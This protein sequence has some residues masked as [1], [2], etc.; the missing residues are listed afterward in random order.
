ML[1]FSVLVFYVFATI[2]LVSSCGV[3][4]SRNPVYSAL[5]LVVVFVA[6]AGIWL[7]LHAEFLALVLV[8]VYVG[9]VM[10]LFLFVLMM[11]DINLDRLREGFWH[12]LPLALLLAIG[13]AWALGTVLT[14]E[15]FV[16]SARF[17]GGVE[18][19]NTRA[20]GAVLYTD[21][22]YP[23]E[24]AAVILLVA[25]IA[26]VAL[27]LRRRK[28]TKHTDVAQQVCADRESRVRLISM[29]GGG[30]APT[31]RLTTSKEELS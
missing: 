7:L 6:S 20:L 15:N 12:Y 22:A 16:S 24:L 28:N 18:S 26:A 13:V 31:S 14:N 9:A 8:L 30:D 21:Y 25:I 1:D 3:I 23:F 5:F 2:V 11:L 19:N 4:F 29:S 10:V 17:A 27:T